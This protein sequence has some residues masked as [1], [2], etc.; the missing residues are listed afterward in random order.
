MFT[1]YVHSKILLSLLGDWCDVT[2]VLDCRYCVD[3]FVG[4]STEAQP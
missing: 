3:H 1:I 2:I 4:D